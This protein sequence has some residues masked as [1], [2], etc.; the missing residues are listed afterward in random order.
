M[1]HR[2]SNDRFAVSVKDAA[3]AYVRANDAFTN[4]LGVAPADLPGLT[5]DQVQPRDVAETLVAND[6]SALSASGT[7]LTEESVFDRLGLRKVAACRFVTEEDGRTLI[8]RVSGVPSLATEV[9]AE[10]E[11]LRA[12]VLMPVPEDPVE[13]VPVEPVLMAEPVAE[14]VA[15][16]PVLP[17]P[18]LPE[19]VLPEPVVPDP[20]LAD[21]IARISRLE[22]ELA[23]ARSEAALPDPRTQAALRALAGLAE[24]LEHPMRVAPAF[25]AAAERLASAL[26]FDA[27][28][29]WRPARDGGLACSSVWTA[30]PDG[31]AF[32]DACWR[33]RRA[34]FAQLAWDPDAAEPHGMRTVVTVPIGEAGAMEL[35]AADRR[36]LEPETLQALDIAARHLRL[37]ARLTELADLPRWASIASN[38]TT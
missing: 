11:R 18:V 31:R 21:A 37:V 1:L 10:A 6:R 24:A 16:E 36:E 28:V 2:M 27:A 15:V 7:L 8:W 9:A 13:A 20:A 30:L 22:A 25:R 26:G 38:A 33:T 19:P 3:G 17:E 23:E 4:L 32:E 14:A 5:D 29:T 35:L 34:P 12:A